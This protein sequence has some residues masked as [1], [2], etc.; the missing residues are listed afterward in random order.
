MS[1]LLN[2]D[3]NLSFPKSTEFPA[4]TKVLVI[5]DV[6]DIQYVLQLYLQCK[7]AEVL[8]SDN[9][10]DGIELALNAKPDLILMDMNLPDINGYTA[11]RRLRNAG[12]NQQ[13]IAITGHSMSGDR[14]KCLLA[15]C[16]DYLSKPIDCE[17]LFSIVNERIRK[18]RI[19]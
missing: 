14:E 18:Q 12:F 9:A 1:T 4:D 17:A 19:H 13:I 2:E 7:G 15:G 8:T 11:T 6:P 10:T 16:D 3:T 5:D